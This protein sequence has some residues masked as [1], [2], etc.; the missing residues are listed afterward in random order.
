MAGEQGAARR[1]LPYD[2]HP[3]SAATLGVGEFRAH[4]LL[5]GRSA[6]K[7]PVPAMAAAND[8][9]PRGQG[10]ALHREAK[11]PASTILR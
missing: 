3:S 11:S 4:G 6:H 7:Q 5:R 2:V 8:F 1:I 9:P 10:R